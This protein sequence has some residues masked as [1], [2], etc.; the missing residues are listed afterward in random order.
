MRM[1]EDIIRK[2]HFTEKSNMDAAFG[3]YTFQVDVKATKP[4]IKA[5]VE[6]LFQVKVLS[7]NTMNYNGKVKRMGVH[8]GPRSKWKK[9]IVT[10][11]TNPENETYIAKGGKETG[12]GKKYKTSIAEFGVAE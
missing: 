8:E 3:R 5:A 7:V 10:I 11:D 2:P 6:E 1:P 4:E 9:A 12:T